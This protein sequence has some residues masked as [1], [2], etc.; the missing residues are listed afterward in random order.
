MIER[1]ETK[2]LSKV[3]M[4]T[5]NSV[6]GG[7]RTHKFELKADGSVERVGPFGYYGPVVEA[8]N[9]TEAQIRFMQFAFRACEHTPK[10]K[11]KNGAYQLAYES[12]GYGINVESGV[13][14]RENTLCL[15]GVAD[16][17]ALN[18]SCASFDYYASEAYR[19]ANFE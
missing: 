13:E 11:V 16:W 2:A 5:Q 17:S 8:R 14:G 18:D 4:T 1:I 6:L 9:K 7:D 3:N 15:S 19:L 10:V 12:L